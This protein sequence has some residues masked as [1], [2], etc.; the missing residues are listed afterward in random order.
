VNVDGN[1]S[2]H[3][4]IFEPQPPALKP[5]K[6]TGQ[7]EQHWFTKKIANILRLA[8]L[9]NGN[10][11]TTLLHL[12]GQT[13]VDLSYY[14]ARTASA[15]FTSNNA[16]SAV[17]KS[18]LGPWLFT[19][20]IA[21]AGGAEAAESA[22]QPADNGNGGKPPSSGSDSRN[23]DSSRGGDDGGPG[24]PGGGHSHGGSGGG[25]GDIPFEAVPVEGGRQAAPSDHL[26]ENEIETELESDQCDSDLKSVASDHSDVDS[27]VE[28]DT[29]ETTL[30]NEFLGQHQEEIWRCDR[31]RVIVSITS[32]FKR[33]SLHFP[34]DLLQGID[35]IFLVYQLQECQILKL[36]SIDNHTIL[37]LAAYNGGCSDGPLLHGAKLVIMISARWRSK[38]RL[39][40]DPA[41][42]HSYNTLH[43][44]SRTKHLSRAGVAMIEPVRLFKY[45]ASMGFVSCGPARRKNTP[46]L[47]FTTMTHSPKR[48]SDS[49]KEFVCT[50]DNGKPALSDGWRTLFRQL[51]FATKVLNSKGLALGQQAIDMAVLT[52]DSKICFPNL[53]RS[54]LFPE[55][56]NTFSAQALQAVPALN[57]QNTSLSWPSQN[58]AGASG[59]ESMQATFI[60][61]TTVYDIMRD[62]K[63]FGAGVGL[64]VPYEG[65]PEKSVLHRDTAFKKDQKF[66]TNMLV[67]TLILCHD[68]P[69]SAAKSTP[70]A[71]ERGTQRAVRRAPS[72]L[73]KVLTKAA[74]LAKMKSTETNIQELSGLLV[75]GGSKLNTTHLSAVY[76]EQPAFKRLAEFV[77]KSQGGWTCA[78]AEDHHFLTV[79]ICDPMLGI[80]V[81]GSG[82]VV[83]ECQFT[84]PADWTVEDECPLL[85][86]KLPRVIVKRESELKGT[87]V[88]AGRHMRPGELVLI[89]LGEYEEDAEIRPST[90]M[91]VKHT[92]GQFCGKYCFGIESLQTCLAVGPSLG[93]YANSPGRGEK[94]NCGL[95][96]KHVF[97]CKNNNGKKMIGYPIYAKMSIGEGKPILWPYPADAGRGKNFSRG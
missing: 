26:D 83:D 96:R 56:N 4:K 91:V 59:V 90:R 33:C 84:L 25:N 72:P 35:K 94:A 12:D 32:E 81:N 95:E 68:N 92:C 62:A 11:R 78:E 36:D 39:K 79:F 6:T 65:V 49:L 38:S 23:D 28:I 60:G 3:I 5:G 66:A 58:G 37:V 30:Q 70:A 86:Q 31:E 14:I 93:S 13:K 82:V 48:L 2:V 29:V 57:R 77:V 76:N 80:K 74:K 20:L 40:N 61:D 44:S 54:V 22:E 43:M 17:T 10:A 41:L 24:R 97:T 27:D 45:G 71:P 47:G 87:G 34:D 85:G 67:Q 15:L 46:V 16:P 9:K 42:R 88:F 53:S 7:T 89:Y 75:K 8:G 64:L 55:G 1:K 69:D 18:L 63:K 52:E 51:V 21:V 73:A 50:D 19:T